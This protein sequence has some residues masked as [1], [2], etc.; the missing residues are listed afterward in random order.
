MQDAIVEEYQSVHIAGGGSTDL[1]KRMARRAAKVLSVP[2]AH[3]S[4]DFDVLL[5]IA[6]ARI[7]KQVQKLISC[8]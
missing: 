5:D 7:N 8:A 3:G 1:A 2:R 6:M 4:S